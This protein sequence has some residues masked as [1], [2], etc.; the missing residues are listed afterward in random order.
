MAK[1]ARAADDRNENERWGRAA[2]QLALTMSEEHREHVLRETALLVETRPV[3]LSH[4][5]LSNLARQFWY[6]INDMVER[7]M[8]PLREK[9]D[10]RRAFAM[11]PEVAQVY[12]AHPEAMALD[13]CNT[14]GYYAP[15]MVV[16]RTD[17]AL[18][19]AGL[20]RH[21]QSVFPRCPLCGGHLSYCSWPSVRYVHREVGRIRKFF[22]QQRRKM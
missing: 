4:P 5:E 22:A 21:V 12:L 10:S 15:V 1:P 8:D 2:E 17:Y 3:D 13:K 14:C 6:S 9:C 20:D 11:P 19:V 18:S 7:G 16:A